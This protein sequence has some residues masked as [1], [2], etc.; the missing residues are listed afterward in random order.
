MRTTSNQ[1][2]ILQMVAIEIKTLHFDEANHNTKIFKYRFERKL[3]FGLI[4]YY[5]GIA[6]IL[7]S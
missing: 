7:S 3:G 4:N 2:E 6:I 5:F 1:Q